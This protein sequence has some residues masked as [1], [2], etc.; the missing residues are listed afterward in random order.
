MPEVY[1]GIFCNSL[2]LSKQAFLLT[3]PAV[4]DILLTKQ[5]YSPSSVTVTAP[6]SVLVSTSGCV[7]GQ[8]PE[9]KICCTQFS[10]SL[11][12]VAAC[13]LKTSCQGCRHKLDFGVK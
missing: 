13:K 11:P 6:E 1:H 7:C 4:V 10:T 5:A 9:I 8:R 12:S 2:A 3:M